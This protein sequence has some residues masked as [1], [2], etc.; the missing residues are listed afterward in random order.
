M[1]VPP[2]SLSVKGLQAVMGF[3]TLAHI[4]WAI[5]LKQGLWLFLLS[6]PYPCL[7]L[8][9]F[10]SSLWPKMPPY[11]ASCGLARW[12]KAQLPRELCWE[13]APLS[14]LTSAL[15]KI[16]QS[17][18]K[19]FVIKQFSTMNICNHV[20]SRIG[21]TTSSLLIQQLGIPLFHKLRRT[22]RQLWQVIISTRTL[23]HST[24]MQ[25]RKVCTLD[26]SLLYC[27]SH[28]QSSTHARKGV[29]S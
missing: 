4:W 20:A 11:S 1:F 21:S 17:L 23:F 26:Q 16:I 7:T 8:Q 12:S 18:I 3:W 25:S 6:I 27:P 29:K 5:L 15:H 10:T 24:S 14:K 19:R 22:S 28:W 2:L 13:N 9:Y